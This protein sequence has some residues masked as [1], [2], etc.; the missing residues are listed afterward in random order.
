MIPW[1]IDISVV[2]TVASVQR[3]IPPPANRTIVAP[4]LCN[5]SSFRI[6][7]YRGHGT[8]HSKP[9]RMNR[10]EKPWVANQAV[11]KSKELTSRALP[12]LTLSDF[13]EVT[14]REGDGNVGIIRSPLRAIALPDRS[15]LK[16]TYKKHRV[17]VGNDF[18]RHGT[19]NA[20]SHLPYTLP[21]SVSGNSFV[22]H[23]YENCRVSPTIFFPM[24]NPEEHGPT[25]YHLSQRPYRA[26]SVGVQHG[27]MSRL[28]HHSPPGL[29]IV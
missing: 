6:N 7:T 5:V 15:A 21:S 29:T 9:F 19:F 20:D 10:L 2:N 12:C 18:Q 28:A 26:S 23:S 17:G 24:W 1:R 27:A 22:C 16:D 14:F 11:L 3:P 13:H 4:F 25:W 8:V